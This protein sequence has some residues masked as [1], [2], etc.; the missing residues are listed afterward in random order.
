MAQLGTMSSLSDEEIIAQNPIGNGLD[1]F[2]RLFR[3]KCEDL[4]VSEV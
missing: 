3:E 4:G 1:D 2:R